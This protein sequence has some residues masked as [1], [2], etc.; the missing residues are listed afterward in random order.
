MEGC[1]DPAQYATRP[2]YD[3]LAA[4]ARG[5]IGLDHRLLHALVD[6][7]GR[8]LADML[9]FSMEKRDEDRVVLEEDLVSIFRH[10]KT[11]EALP[12][13]IETVRRQPHDISDELVE[14]FSLFPEESSRRLLD[15]YEELGEEEGEE[16]AFLLASLRVRDER[17]LKILLDRLES[18]PGEA[19][20]CL[21]LYGDAAARPALERLLAEGVGKLEDWARQSV[22]EAI[23]DLDRPAPQVDHPVFDIWEQYP[24]KAPPQFSILDESKRLE[25]LSSPSAEFRAG[26][27]GSFLD[28]ELNDAACDRLLKTGRED[29]DPSVRARAWEALGSALDRLAVRE[30]L[31]SRLTDKSAP[32][33]ERC[34]AMVGLA[35][36]AD[37]P[38]V[39]HWIVAFYDV[40]EARAKSLEA[41]SRSLDR[42]FAAFFPPHL[43]DADPEIRRQAIWGVGHLGIHTEAARLRAY[44]ED[45]EFRED[46]LYAYALSVP[47]EISRGRAKALLRKVASDAGGLSLAEGELVE[48]AIDE[49]LALHGLEPVFKY[50]DEEEEPEPVPESTPPVKPGRNDPCPCGSGKKFKKCCGA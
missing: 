1:L 4:A 16:V 5:E 50:S 38:A 12:Y 43:D 45:E 34:G 25:L 44:F 23:S 10:L 29:S 22:E 18:D 27:A 30:A 26:A 42:R 9:R 3:L 35:S 32:V 13:F 21:G 49:R 6:D 17:I 31:L 47:A 20:F 8:S 19:A 41:M 48:W 14:A 37:D 7:P 39:R 33:E 46:A 40:P 28:E 24:E 11:P 15:L 36:E 2:A